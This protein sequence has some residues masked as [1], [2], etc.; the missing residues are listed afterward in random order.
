MLITIP[1]CSGCTGTGFF[2]KLRKAICFPSSARWAWSEQLQQ[3][4][5]MH[6]GG[7]RGPEVTEPTSPAHCPGPVSVAGAVVMHIKLHGGGGNK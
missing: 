3:G 6:W 5:T 7:T 2:W 1:E 4:Q